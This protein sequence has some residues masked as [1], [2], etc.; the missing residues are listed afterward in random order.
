SL[1]PLKFVLIHFSDNTGSQVGR[2]SVDICQVAGRQC[3]IFRCIF[4]V[5][6]HFFVENVVFSHDGLKYSEVTTLFEQEDDMTHLIRREWQPS[7]NGGFIIFTIDSFDSRVVK[8]PRHASISPVSRD[9][10]TT[11][12]ES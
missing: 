11:R 6:Y 1:E 3:C 12:D 8:E 9:I 10:C 2:D 5:C 7:L 4:W